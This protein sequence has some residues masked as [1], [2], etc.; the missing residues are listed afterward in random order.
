[1]KPSE[2]WKDWK[3][4]E[5]FRVLEAV[6]LLDGSCWIWI[7][8]SCRPFQSSNVEWIFALISRRPTTPL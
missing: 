2:H 6:S 8:R 7:R 3:H 1:M 5:T 4:C